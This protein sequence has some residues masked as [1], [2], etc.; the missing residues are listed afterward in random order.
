MKT[1]DL[2][3]RTLSLFA[4]SGFAVAILAPLT[5]LAS[6]V[7]AQATE[8]NVTFDACFVKGDRIPGR[9]IE[10]SLN[11]EVTV[12]HPAFANPASTA[13]LKVSDSASPPKIIFNV[14]C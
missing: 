7:I 4:L 12:D 5:G 8:G 10:Y 11:V 13:T 9:G 2:R 6:K 1:S 14:L 3:R